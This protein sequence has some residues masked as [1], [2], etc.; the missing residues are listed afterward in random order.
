[1]SG[2][3]CEVGCTVTDCALLLLLLQIINMQHVYFRLRNGTAGRHDGQAQGE[4]KG[5]YKK[6]GKGL[7]RLSSFIGYLDV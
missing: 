3:V 1:V 6:A 4:D 7:H 2:V 5:K